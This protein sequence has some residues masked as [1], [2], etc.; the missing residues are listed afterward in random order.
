MK[1]LMRAREKYL[2]NITP[3]EKKNQL[4]QFFFSSNDRILRMVKPKGLK[5][6]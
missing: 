6:S 3:K 2:K 5:N 1:N 4:P